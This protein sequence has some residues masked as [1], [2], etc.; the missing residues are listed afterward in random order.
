M[1]ARVAAENSINPRLLL[2]L[3]EY[4]GGWVYGT[5]R[6]PGC[7]RLPAGVCRSSPKGLY[8]QLIWAVNQ[9]SIG[10]Y[11]YRE[12]RLTEINF[13]DGSSA[14]LAPDL[15]AG[16]A[17][18]Q[19]FFAQ[20]Y[21]RPA[22]RRCARPKERFS[23]PATSKC[24]AIPGSG[25]ARSSRSSRPGLKQPPLSLPFVRNWGWSY[26]GGPHGA[27]EQ[28]G[29]YAA[30]DFAPGSVESGCIEF[31]H[32]GDCLRLRPGGALGQRR[33]R[34]GPGWR[35]AGANRLGAGL[36]ARLPPTGCPPA[37]GWTRTITW[38]GLLARAAF[39]PARMSTSPENITANGSR[40]MG[41]CLS[42]WAAGWPALALEAYK[43]TLTRDGQT[44]IACTCS[45]STSSN[46]RGARTTHRSMP[47]Y[48]RLVHIPP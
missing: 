2:A 28:D 38:G 43:G 23:G 48:V 4:Q 35:W 26:T 21:D 40:Q 8:R 30:L 1:I 22:W 17:A 15:N 42:T 47:C 37:P 11:A 6:Q 25:P 9:L 20:L 46:R 31:E 39:P 14:R 44:L 33:G 34:A 7:R 13:H 19:Y 41:R 24:M 27:W 29:A 5:A 36:P 32:L 10:Y 3:L 45:N 18:L 12:G 16:T